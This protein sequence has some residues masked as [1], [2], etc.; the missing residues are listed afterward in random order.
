MIALRLAALVATL[1]LFAAG[2][3]G[4]DDTVDTTSPTP[5]TPTTPSREHQDIVLELDR[6]TAQP[7]DVLELTI[8][9][10]TPTRWEY[11]AAYRLERRT[12][13]G[14]RWVN[15][16]QAFILLLK[17]LEPRAREREEI[18]LPDDL[19]PGRYRIVK[20]FTDPA[21]GEETRAKAT[22]TVS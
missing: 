21:A 2:C 20:S 7:G 14:W 9:N 3:G 17:V 19:E 1:A 11:G 22:F 16:D 8:D 15:R 5:T 4:D 18:G 13:D 6:E 10:R 12:D